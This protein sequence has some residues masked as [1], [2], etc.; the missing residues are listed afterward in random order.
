MIHKKVKEEVIRDITR[1]ISHRQIAQRHRISTSTVSLIRTQAGIESELPLTKFTK[2]QIQWLWNN[3]CKKHGKRFIH[4]ADC[5]YSECNGQTGAERIGLF[6]IE[7]SNLKANFG[8]CLCYRFTLLGSGKVFGATITP[9]DLK[10]GDFDKRLIQQFVQ[11]CKKFDRLV[12][13]YS[14]RF[15]IPFMR[16]RAMI[17]DVDFPSAG[18][19]YQSDTWRMARDKLLLSS[20][21]L[22]TIET[23][24][25]LPVNK[26]EIMPEHWLG[27]LSGN[28]KAIDYIGDHCDKDVLVL[29]MVYNKLAKY[30]F[31]TNTSI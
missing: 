21:R 26:T 17:L 6:D 1:G 13:H 27:A 5:F 11:D 3:F 16:T 23:A 20:N 22:K 12:G 29:E 7:A 24:L 31:K 4:C 9:K 18:E 30:V 19:L 25:N 14:S 15:D 2:S 10:S 8:I 28:Q